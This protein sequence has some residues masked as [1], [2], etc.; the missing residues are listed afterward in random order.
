MRRILLACSLC[1]ALALLVAPATLAAGQETTS[2]VNWLRQQQ[3]PDGGFAGLNGKTDP[4]TTAD[5]ALALSAAGIDPAGVTK[6][7]KSVIDFLRANAAGYGAST[8]GAAKLALAAESA[9]LDPRAF[10]GDDLIAKLQ[11]A[12]D[13]KTG[14][15]DP[16]VY[17][18]GLAVLALSGAG[19]PLGVD[20]VQGLTSHQGAD[21][22][23][24][25]DGDTAPGKGDS[26]T[27]AIVLQALVAA[28]ASGSPAIQRGLAYMAS[29]RTPN[30]SY[31]SQPGQENPPVGDANSTALAIETLLA[32]GQTTR[33]PAVSAALSALRSLQNPSGAFAYRPD[34][35]QDNL[36]ATVQAIPA[37]AGWTY[38]PRTAG[39]VAPDTGQARDAVSVAA[40]AAALAL[41]ALAL[42]GALRLRAVR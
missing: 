28:G 27:T 40:L 32:T 42:G 14:L 33:S 9:G 21:G 18:D 19:A 15:Y 13:A 37:L 22:S 6:D 11:A 8:G 41:A 10:S 29:A 4:S 16:Q 34:A 3:Q 39:A 31:V 23:W 24:A 38:L 20:V 30:G 12:Y 7:G 1:L 17:V 35:K 26:N 5:V 36:L 25:F 2:A